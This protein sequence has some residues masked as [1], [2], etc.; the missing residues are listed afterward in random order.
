MKRSLLGF[1]ASTAAWFLIGSGV[2]VSAR[3]DDAQ[4]V[5]EL[6]LNKLAWRNI[7]PAIMGGR[8][9]DIVAVESDPRIIY[10]AA[11]SG[12]LWKTTNNGVTWTP[13]F[14][15]QPLSSIGAVAVAPSDPSVVWVGTGEA[16]NR[17]SSSWGNGMYKST[18][19]GNTWTHM[20][21]ADTHH[22]G[23]IVIHPQNPQIVYVAAAGH[24]WGPNKERGLYKTTDGGKTW[25]NTQFINEN[26][27]FIDV[28][29]DPRNPETLYAAAYQRRRTAFGFNG[30]GPHSGLYK[31]TDGGGTWTRL[32]QGLP[33][34]HTGRIGI[35]VARGNPDVVYAVVENAL[36]GVFRSSDKGASWT[37]MS[38]LNPRPHYYSKLRVD[39]KNDQ[40]IWMLGPDMYYSEDGGKSFDTDL[41]SR[42]HGDFHAMW[43]NP[44][45]SDHLILGSDG[46]I[47]L[48]YDRGRTWDYMNAVP[49]GQFYAIS[50]D[51]EQPYN[52]Y[53]GLQD[54]GIW[55]G[56]ARTL[57][58]QGIANDD[59]FELGGGDGSFA[60]PDPE[61][62]STV[63]FTSQYGEIR[64][65]DLKSFETK[66]IQPQPRQGESANR[67]DWLSP[68]LISPHNRHTIYFGGNRLLKS[69]DRGDS[70]TGSPDLTGDPDR[71]RMP[72]MDVVV[73]ER[74]LSGH[75]GDA[76]FGEIVTVSESPLTEGVLYVGTDDGN[77]QVSRDG[78]RTWKN[79]TDRITGVPKGTYVSGV[80][81]SRFAEGRVYAVF[82]GHRSDDFRPYV[83][84][85]EDFGERWQSI[86]SDL[87][88]G[89][90]VS[91]IREHPRRQDLLFVGTERGAFV[92]FARGRTWHRLGGR[93]PNVPVD[94][95]AIHP[96][97]NDLV[98]GT[99]GRSIWVL[100]DLTPLEEFSD[101]VLDS[102][103]HGFG[104]R[105]A[106][107]YRI[108][109][110]RASTGHKPFIAPNP[111][112][113]AL[114][115]YYL[116]SKPEQEVRI[117]ISDAGGATIR[118]L[119]GPGEA[120]LNRASWDL[121][122]PPPFR[123]MGPDTYFIA[124]PQWRPDS[125]P[126]GSLVLP[127]VYTVKIS[128]GGLQTT[129]TVKVVED[130]R[131]QV[132][133]SDRR[134]NL[135]AVVRL[136]RMLAQSESGERAIT[137]LQSQLATVRET[138]GADP[139]ASRAVGAALQAV[140]AK[141]DALEQRLSHTGGITRQLGHTGPPPSGRPVPIYPRINRLYGELNTYTRAP[142]P[143]QQARMEA[144]SKELLALL[145][146]LNGLI[147]GDVPKLNRVL[148]QNK[149]RPVDPGPRVEP[150]PG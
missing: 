89:H 4:R 139:R 13:I 86:S 81:A 104:I 115:H 87:P 83:Y 69:V 117:T 119:R 58:R 106:T 131:V 112:Y 125:V 85:S 65:V 53:G 56:P 105:Q 64:R 93:F 30:G 121:R 91:V 17:Q 11:A 103:I 141:V 26:T 138:L 127:G 40:R 7:G 97:D 6:L 15:G 35:D 90:T 47:H 46:G 66:S 98:L 1:V 129:Q 34:G 5:G 49:L 128:A 113:G 82:D 118:E 71:D 124:P 110:H 22:I 102:E 33:P 60:V 146:E 18:D 57:Y 38:P 48:S 96:R 19:G 126:E 42:I 95:L 143:E 111:P 61:D 149:L 9:D 14:D 101:A 52:V 135:Q 136:G 122:Y 100:D 116:K 20:G 74:T 3:S 73:D 120:G 107:T 23:R 79:V 148:T 145:G 140:S 150:P 72:I 137:N 88:G 31:T 78:S 54:N 70:W 41:V 133:E 77:V 37:R 123:R 132:S 16:N 39:P 10:V 2:F 44:A 92:S 67:F 12:G 109:S 63:Y 55:R 147:E 142:L 32:G 62:P 29:L 50:L 28:A 45:N 36:G 80:V 8:I 130:P 108:H 75:D 94:D 68:I 25:T 134:A 114:I 43:I 51:M 99:H 24:L 144:F 76:T 84:V 27:G 59:W 21:L